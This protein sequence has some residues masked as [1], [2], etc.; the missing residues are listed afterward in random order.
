MY[1][2]EYMD[3]EGMRVAVR[4]EIESN[5]RA[6]SGYGTNAASNLQGGMHRLSW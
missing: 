2:K 4:F 6:R 3:E 5:E 1:L